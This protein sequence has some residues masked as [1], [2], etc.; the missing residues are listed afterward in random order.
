MTDLPGI[1]TQL[2]AYGLAHRDPRGDTLSVV[3]EAI[4]AAN[5]SG[6]TVVIDFTA[7][8]CTN[9]HVI[10]KTILNVNPAK[11]ALNARNVVPMKVDL[12]LETNEVG[13]SKLREISGGSGIPLTAIYLP[14]EPEPVIFRSFYGADSLIEVLDSAAAAA[15]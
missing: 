8:W 13:W 15:R 4:A 2:G 6:K 5:K 14:G 7:K 10:E 1:F 9:C 11:D 3:R 12:T